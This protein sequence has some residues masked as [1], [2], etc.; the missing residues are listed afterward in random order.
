MHEPTLYHVVNNTGNCDGWQ[1]G[2]YSKVTTDN[3]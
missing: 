2:S 1:N 3:G